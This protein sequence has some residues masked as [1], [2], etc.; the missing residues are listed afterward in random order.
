M[1]RKTLVRF[2]TWKCLERSLL[3]VLFSQRNEE[4][5]LYTR[6]PE[7]IFLIKEHFSSKREVFS[8]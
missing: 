7:L 4:E 2:S 8:S 5:A 3:N 6:G 1:E